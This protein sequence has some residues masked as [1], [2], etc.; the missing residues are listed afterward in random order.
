MLIGQKW[1]PKNLPFNSLSIMHFSFHDSLQCLK[2]KCFSNSYKCQTHVI[3][4]KLSR[5]TLCGNICIFNILFKFLSQNMN[6]IGLKMTVFITGRVRFIFEVSDQNA[7][8]W[9]YVKKQSNLNE[10]SLIFPYLLCISNITGSLCRNSVFIHLLQ[11]LF[12]LV[13][14]RMI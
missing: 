2:P 13:K 4:F 1:P 10:D 8:S 11:R 6:M 14:S 5:L 12:D 7:Q 3:D 9:K